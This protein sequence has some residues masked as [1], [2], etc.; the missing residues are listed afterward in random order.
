MR[1]KRLFFI[2]LISNLYIVFLYSISVFAGTD[3]KKDQPIEVTADSLIYDKAKDTYYAEGNVVAVQG[4]SSVKADRMTVDM[5]A[6]HAVAVGNVEAIDE[7]GN[8]LKGD[9]WE[10][11][12]DTKVGVVMN[13][14]LFFKRENV[15][16]TGEEVKKTGEVSYSIH[17]GYFTTC[18]CE[19][20][21]SPAWSFYSSDAGVT[22]GE[23]LTA[24]NAFFYIKDVPVLYSPYISF[25]VKRGRETGFL[26]PRFGYSRLRG[27]KF[28]NSFF[29]AISDSA[30]ATF[31]LDIETR[32]GLGKAIE[33]RYALSSASGGEFYFYHF[34]EKDIERVREFRKGSNN[35]SRP[36]TAEDDRWFLKYTHNG[37]LPDDIALKANIN[38][39]S[40]DEYFID[41]GKDI[42]ERSLESL[43]SNI[44]L[45]KTWDK[46]NLV[47]QFRYF[48]NL[49]VESN[50]ATL[51]RLPEITLAGSDKQIMD[52]P[53][54]F[55]L[56]SSFVNFERKEGSTGQR[57]DVHPTVSLPLNP[58]GYF[59]FKPSA[60]ARETLY[61]VKNLP[62]DRFHDR[63]SYDLSADLTT[64]FVKT[65]TVD[66]EQ[67]GEGLK[68]LRHTIRPKIVYTYI[69]EQVQDDLPQFD[70]VDRIAQRNDFTYSINSI[71]TGKFVDDGN[72]SYRDYIYLDLS[73]SYN[74][75]EATRKLT[76]ATDKRRPFSD[77]T[78][79]IRI[80][81]IQ[82][83]SITSKGKYDTYEG[84]MK[85][86]DSSLG[87]WDKRGDRVD[88]SYRYTRSPA[89]VEYLDLSMRLKLIQ[90]VDLTYT[91]RYAYS[92]KHP[93][94][95][96][97]GLEYH[98]Q[99][100][101]AQL[102]YTERLEE[103]I[104]FL[105]FNLL[106]LGQ[107]GGMSGNVK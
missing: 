3:L 75:N 25:P 26:S 85:E 100:W 42:K 88:V 97:Y 15:H 49:L 77:V 13:G 59:E 62:Q 57:V 43:E 12:I 54:Y 33:Y 10:L 39:V 52:S 106:G 104:V 72:L 14:K 2:L 9:N 66:E 61:W 50:R 51:Q 63:T 103:K 4:K 82:W 91:K 56:D 74:I 41:F 55:S 96:T 45:T 79:E 27:F 86:Y 89:P 105:S 16:I 6:S 48:D 40:D 38:K 68:K 19:A 83:T 21:E 7:E 102:T 11:N 18:D 32:R 37:L 99:C 34:K 29:W 81:P 78:G 1:N 65:S 76:S 73:Q 95:D 36:K 94:E 17:N 98:H 67:A 5:T 30:D 107:V 93:I 53:F 20:D 58:G 23:Y 47:T 64:T 87:L 46:F 101:G 31:Y 71:L 80:M 24:W 22:F 84:L 28:D 8:S 44:S 90:S 92:D 69:P 70:G 35:L 60:G